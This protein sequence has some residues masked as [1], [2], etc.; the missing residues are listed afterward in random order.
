MEEEEDAPEEEPE[1]EEAPEAPLEVPLELLL[2]PVE[3]PPVELPPVEED[4]EDEEEEE[5]AEASPGV[6]VGC[7]CDRRMV[8]EAGAG[9]EAA[10]GP[11]TEKTRRR[12]VVRPVGPMTVKFWNT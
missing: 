4:E 11:A 5:V 9:A 6:M 12:A 1:E 10:P 3:P 7:G 2:R 8:T